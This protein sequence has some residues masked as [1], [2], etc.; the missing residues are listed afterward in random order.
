MKIDYGQMYFFHKHLRHL[1]AWLENSTGLD[2]TGTSLYRP[3]DTG[4]HGQMP[5]RGTDLRMRSRV[6]GEAIE[7]EINKAWIYDTKRPAMKCA[8]LHGEGSNMHLH[9]QVHQN[10]RRRNPAVEEIPQ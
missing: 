8:I 10:T 3:G 1:I 7:S 9:L 4:V 5:V 6:I 2:F